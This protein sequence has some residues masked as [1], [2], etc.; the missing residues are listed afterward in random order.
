MNHIFDNLRTI[1]VIFLGFVIVV[2]WIY[3]LYVTPT[4]SVP[5]LYDPLRGTEVRSELGHWMQYT[6]SGYGKHR[7]RQVIHH[8][9]CP[10][11]GNSMKGK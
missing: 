1:L 9:A 4:N 7:T 3:F 6:D 2:A 10:N 5:I 8:P 11:D